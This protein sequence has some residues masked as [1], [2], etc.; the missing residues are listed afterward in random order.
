MLQK[1]KNSLG[2]VFV[3]VDC[4]MKVF[5]TA[6]LPTEVNANFPPEWEVSSYSHLRSMTKQELT[7][8]AHKGYA[9]LICTYRDQLTSALLSKALPGL[10][11]IGTLS[12]GT[13][14]VD[15]DFC[16]KHQ[17]KVHNASSKL[18]VNSVADYTLGLLLLAVRRLDL[19]MNLELDNNAWHYLYNCKGVTLSSLKVGIVGL[20]QI[21]QAIAQR[22][23]A[24]GSTVQYF[25]RQAK[26]DVEQKMGL[27]YQPFSQLLS[28]SD[29][30]IV[31]C[32]LNDETRNLFNEK[33]FALAKRNS[34]FINV[35]RGGVCDH[36]ALH[37]VLD[38]RH[39]KSAFLD[40][41]YPEPLPA[42]HPLHSNKNCFIFP[43]IAT[44]V[45]NSR[46]DIANDIIEKIERSYISQYQNV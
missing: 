34:I 46:V 21:G 3:F 23:V 32:S 19:D 30:I 17:I 13:D 8:V 10:K 7:E 11:I 40:V 27:K 1:I 12:V 6:Q 4:F 16:K 15:L 29:V 45:I 42:D 14:H 2:G 31:S 9:A 25:S 44:N 43:H 24:F 36:L 26:L 39:I 28:Q 38:S 37:K 33:S 18:M 20:G 41:T 5:V 22:L 35:S